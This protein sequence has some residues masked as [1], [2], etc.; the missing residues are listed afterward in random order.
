MSIG[1]LLANDDD[2]VV[3]RGPRKTGMIMQFLAETNFGE[4]DF[5]IIDTPPGTSDEHL[6]MVQGLAA[7]QPDGAV[8]VTTPQDVALMDVRKEISFA[9]KMNLR[10]LGLIENMCGFACPDCEHTTYIFGR[11]GG[12]KLADEAG[13]PFLGRIPLDAALAESEENGSSFMEAYPESATAKAWKSVAANITTS[14]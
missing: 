3:W 11:G 2:P 9:R 4:L 10:T 13:M 6:A 14:L 5:L 8:I 7:A 12:Q 1:F